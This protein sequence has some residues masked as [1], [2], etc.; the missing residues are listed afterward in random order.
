L[1]CELGAGY[2]KCES[3]SLLLAITSGDIR[4]ND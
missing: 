1:A 3:S 4:D 2:Q